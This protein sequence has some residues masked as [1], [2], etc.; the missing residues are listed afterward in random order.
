MC[1]GCL[2]ELNGRCNNDLAL[3]FVPCFGG[4][5]AIFLLVV[6]G[7]YRQQRLKTHH[8]R[9]AAKFSH[10]KGLAQYFRI[11]ERK[12]YRKISIVRVEMNAQPIRRGHTRPE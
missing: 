2:R 11:I 5:A 9:A 8:G 7:E 1:A 10:C 3:P 4:L 12:L 6:C